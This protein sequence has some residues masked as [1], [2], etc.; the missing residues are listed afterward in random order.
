VAVGAGH[1]MIGVGGECECLSQLIGCC[2]GDEA[3]VYVGVGRAGEDLR[4]SCERNIQCL[5][6]VWINDRANPSSPGNKVSAVIFIR[7]RSAMPRD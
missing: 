7:V 2:D 4:P 5:I 6:M 3:G 1:G